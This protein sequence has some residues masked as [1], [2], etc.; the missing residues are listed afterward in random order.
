MLFAGPLALITSALVGLLGSAPARAAPGTPGTIAVVFGPPTLVSKVTLGDT[1]IDGPSLWA[2]PSGSVRAVLAWTGIDPQHHLNVMRSANNG[3]TYTNKLV[4]RELSATRPAVVR[5]SDA[6]GGAVTLAWT[7]TDP[8]HTLNVLFDVYGAHPQKLTLWGETSFTSP[9]LAAFNGT[10]LLAWS[11]TD[12]NQTLNAMPITLGNGLQA[13]HKT[14]LPANFNSLAR[15]SLTLDATGARVI[16]SWTYRAPANRLGFASST[17]G[18]TWI[19][20]SASSPLVEFSGSGPSMAA[21]AASNMP[22][23]LMAWTG[24]DAAHSV[25]V[26]YTESYPSWPRDHSKAILAEQAL[27]GPAVGFIGESRRYLI[28]WTGTDPQ[29]HLNVGDIGM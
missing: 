3:L 1:S 11:G 10:L 15:P 24:T 20:P 9:A 25:N 7:G 12:T 28:A 17:N 29:H 27:G 13:G 8:N 21:T 16:L 19:I 22:Q 6:A 2:A 4:V 18:A 14:I 26:Q 23:H 5:M